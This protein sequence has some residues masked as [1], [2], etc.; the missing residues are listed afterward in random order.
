MENVKHV[1]NMQNIYLWTSLCKKQFL[2][3]LDKA[4]QQ[5]W[6]CS[7]TLLSFCFFFVPTRRP[8][9]SFNFHFGFNLMDFIWFRFSGEYS[10]ACWS[11]T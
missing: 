3:G 4:K 10:D 8:C 9:L 2:Y 6:F 11:T 5:T 1:L 7:F